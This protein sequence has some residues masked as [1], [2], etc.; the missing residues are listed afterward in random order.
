MIKYNLLTS[1]SY[2]RAFKNQVHNNGY[3]IEYNVA[4]D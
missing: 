4:G 2:R 1:L 3:D